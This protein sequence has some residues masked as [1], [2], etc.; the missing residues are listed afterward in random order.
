MNEQKKTPEKGKLYIAELT[1]FDHTE[2]VKRCK[3]MSRVS[4]QM[5]MQFC[6]ETPP[7]LWVEIQALRDTGDLVK[8]YYPCNDLMK[9][10]ID[11]MLNQVVTMREIEI[12]VKMD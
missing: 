6:Y 10:G 9:I 8:L 3:M 1:Y 11:V 2:L 7:N 12:R 5:M 4:I